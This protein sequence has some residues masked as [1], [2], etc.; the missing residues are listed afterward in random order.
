MPHDGR[1]TSS[2]DRSGT[3]LSRFF[4]ALGEL[5]AWLAGLDDAALGEAL[6]GLRGGFDRGEAIFAEGLRRYDKSGEYKADGAVTLIAWL[7]D[8]C[9][10]SASAAAE[11]VGVARQLEQLPKTELA[12]ARGEVAYQHVAAIA[13]AADHVGVAAVRKEETSLLQAAGRMDPGQFTNHAKD[14]E[15]RVDAASVLEEANRAHARRYFYVSE[16]I[17]GLVRLDGLLDVEGGAVLRSALNALVPPRKD[18]ERTPGQKRA[19]ALIQLC[20]Q[21]AGR[22]DG[23]GPRPQLIIRANLDTLAGTAGA[24]AGELE[25]GTP[26]PAE[27]VR[28]LAC[29]AAIT[30]IIGAGELDVE[31]SRA[32]RTIPPSTRTALVHRDRH[33]VAGS[34]DRPPSWCDAHHRRHWSDGGRTTLANLVLL[35]RV[36]HNMVHEQGYELRQDTSGRW[37]LIPPMHRTEHHA[38]SA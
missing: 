25:S 20:H 14:F 18:D 17:D 23:T 8:R 35:C 30:R 32:A 37:K 2:G 16:P 24:P 26:I 13:R 12:F 28:R 27:T 21:R 6:V 4:D 19:D 1:M 7:R 9:R 36:H 10:L 11:R 5:P 33:C 38:R 29:D 22:Q 15:H 3:P 34:C 31:I